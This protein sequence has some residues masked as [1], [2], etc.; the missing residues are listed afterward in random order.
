[1]NMHI[2]LEPTQ[3][4][5]RA[6]DEKDGFERK[7]PYVFVCSMSVINGHT[8]YLYAAHG[9][10]N[11]EVVKLIQR[12]LQRLGIEKVITFRNGKEVTYEVRRGLN[13]RGPKPPIG[14]KL[15]TSPEEPH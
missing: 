6:Y 12:E 10:A 11:M 4:V 1:M 9:E 15:E 3:Y 2:H 13:R 8:A 5:I 7:R 14:I